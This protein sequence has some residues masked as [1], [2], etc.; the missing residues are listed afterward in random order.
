MA[1]ITKVARP[2]LRDRVLA[3]ER[4]AQLQV[5]GGAS[6]RISIR[7]QLLRQFGRPCDHTKRL[8]RNLSD[9]RAELLHQLPDRRDQLLELLRKVPGRC[10]EGDRLLRQVVK[11]LQGVGRALE[12]H[13]PNDDRLR[14]RTLHK[15]RRLR[16]VDLVAI[17]VLRNL[18]ATR[19]VANA[20]L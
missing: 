3:G 8:D 14:R 16:N 15:R 4:R 12:D 19:L 6:G 13:S 9:P 17:A 1:C 20:N 7:R 2:R 10:D 18:I 5:L 11:V